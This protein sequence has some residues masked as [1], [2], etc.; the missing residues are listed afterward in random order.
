MV[1]EQ[2]VKEEENLKLLKEQDFLEGDIYGNGTKVDYAWKSYAEEKLLQNPKAGGNVD[3]INTGAFIDSFY[4]LKPKQNKYL[5]GAKDKKRN[6]LVGQYG[7]EIMGLN[8]DVFDKFQIEII[9]PRFVR[10]IKKQLG[11]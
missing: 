10:E 8:Q 9:K 6:K 5:F 2:L 1:N 4:L 11:Q 7:N 3:L